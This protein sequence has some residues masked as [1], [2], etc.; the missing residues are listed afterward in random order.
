MFMACHH[1]NLEVAQLIAERLNFTAEEARDRRNAI[2]RQTCERGNLEVA[3]W[4]V[5]R[6]GLTSQDVCTGDNEALFAACRNNHTEVVKWLAAS[7]DL[8]PAD[9]PANAPAHA[10]IAM[11]VAY[12][13]GHVELAQ[14][15]VEL[16]CLTAEDISPQ[17]YLMSYPL[18]FPSAGPLVKSAAKLT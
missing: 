5:G 1:G 16:F 8:A 14:I 6:Y 4:L 13:N 9:E 15:I 3:Q 12:A 10:K 2:L 11:Q 18:L 17:D 7:F